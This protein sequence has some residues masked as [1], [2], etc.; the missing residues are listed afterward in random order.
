M[1]DGW[2]AVVHVMYGGAER[3][4]DLDD[5]IGRESLALHDINKR[6]AAT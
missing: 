6:A 5:M 3:V 1:C 2:I 4:E